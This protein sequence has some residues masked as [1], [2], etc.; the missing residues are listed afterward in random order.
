MLIK[1][2]Q[3]AS[4]R[5]GKDSVTFKLLSNRVQSEIKVAK[6]HFFNHE[7]A[8]LGKTEMKK[9]WTQIESQTDQDIQ[10]EWLHQVLDESCVDLNSVTNKVNNYFVSLRDGF[11][12]LK[13]CEPAIQPVSPDLLVSLREAH[14]SQSSLNT[15]K[16]IGPD[17]IPNRV[18]KEFVPELAPIIMDIF[19]RSLLEGY[20]PD[21]LK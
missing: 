4:V 13:Y 20:V 1:R 12:A 2:R 3:A 8:D 16:A 21:L 7:V 11:E 9:Y 14:T 18:L 19:N 10:H 15:S 5:D 17:M 6:Y